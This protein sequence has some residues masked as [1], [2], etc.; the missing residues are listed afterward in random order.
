M[1]EREG[2]RTRN[3]KKALGLSLDQSPSLLF[4]TAMKY[5]CEAVSLEGCIQQIAVSYVPNGYFFYVTGFIPISKDPRLTDEK[6]IKKYGIARSKWS[7]ARRKSGGMANVQYIRFRRWFALLATHGRHHFFEEEAKSL[8]DVRETPMQFA[9]YSI[10]FKDGS[11]HVRIARE[12]YSE[13]RAWFLENAL[14]RSAESLSNQLKALHFEPYGGVKKQLFSLL[15]AV[16]EKREQAGFEPVALSSLRLKRTPCKPFE[17]P[18][19][20]RLGEKPDYNQETFT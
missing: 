8:K 19:E 6:L 16:N 11:A 3:V 9:G 14:H 7:R 17:L 15:N 5:N 12:T 10:D 13:I 18:D 4:G 2:S 20:V 1:A